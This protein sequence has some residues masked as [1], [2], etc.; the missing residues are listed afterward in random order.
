MKKIQKRQVEIIT[1]TAIFTVLVI[2]LQYM[3]S[4]I[5]L[6]FFSVSLVLLPII[7]GAAMCGISSG[8]WLGFVFGVV[9]LISGDAAAFMSINFAGT[10]ITVLVKG[11]ACGAAAGIVYKFTEKFGRLLAVVL[12]AVVCP[13]V[14]TGVFI[15]G[16]FTFFYEAITEW[17]AAEGFLS[18]VG[19][20]FLVLVGGNFIFELISNIVLSP[21][22][23]RVLDA[24]KK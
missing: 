17:G 3:G 16:C 4:F 1:L 6:S 10:I 5:R 14:N 11:I 8:I 20:I 2:I 7:I 24:I 22:V 12:A 18:P 13:L 23:V 19:Y 9:V 15:L 21:A